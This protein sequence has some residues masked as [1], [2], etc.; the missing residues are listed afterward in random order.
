MGRRREGRSIPRV[1]VYRMSSQ[2]DRFLV[3]RLIKCDAR[4]LN[5]V[6][7]LRVKNAP[8]FFHAPREPQQFTPLGPPHERTCSRSPPWD[9]VRPRQLL[10][11]R[12][13]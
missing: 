11:G 9:V 13:S 12:S 3:W 1:Q 8:R 6:T 10:M 5:A 2:T 4:G 7:P